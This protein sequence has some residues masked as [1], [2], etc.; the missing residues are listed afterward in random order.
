MMVGS[1]EADIE[2]VCNRPD[3]ADD[4]INDLDIED[5]ETSV[6]NTEVNI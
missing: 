1:L 2:E 6:E 3:E 4:V 5:E